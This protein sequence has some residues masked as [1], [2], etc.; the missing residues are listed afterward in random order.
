MIEALSRSPAAMRLADGRL[1][2][3]PYMAERQTP[4]WWADSL[5]AL[6]L[7]NIDVA[8][9]PLF[10]NWLKHY[11]AYARLSYGVSDWG[12]RRPSEARAW[13]KMAA[14]AHR[15][16]LIW[17]APVVPQDMRPKN[18]K[19]WEAGN[20]ELFRGQW[21][22]AIRGGADWVQ[23]ITWNDYSEHS[24]IRPSTSTGYA[25]YDLAAY[26]IQWFKTGAAPRIQR[27]AIY[28]FYRTQYAGAR[29][30]HSLQAA[31]M[32]PA[33]TSDPPM[34]RVEMLAF[35]TAPAMLEIEL[36]KRVHSMKADAGVTSFVI[37]L[38]AGTPVFRI[39]REERVVA[40]L[41]GVPIRDSIAIQDLLYHGAS[42][43]R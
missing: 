1:V 42:S 6:K 9:V 25:Y 18:G 16:G 11:Q 15:N 3:A 30:D 4:Q 24:V 27:D 12:S 10:H 34:D 13:S 22:A 31:V 21:L 28:S 33:P 38:Q 43:L 41:Q 14:S 37:P 20:S 40:D 17:M 32:K 2:V 36:G 29:P 5:T 19:Y 8:F 26:Y 7:R 35:L 23:L 39:R